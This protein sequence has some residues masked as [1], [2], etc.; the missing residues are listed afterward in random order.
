MTN[1]GPEPIADVTEP[2]TVLLDLPFDEGD[3]PGLR[4]TVAAHATRTSLSAQR[5][6]DLILI[7]SELAA[8]AVRHGGGGGRLRLWRTAGAVHCR[9]TDDGP[10]LPAPY[11]APRQRPDPTV[12][13]GRGLWL[14][15][16]FADAL[17]VGGGPNGGTAV[18]ATMRLP[19]RTGTPGEPPRGRHTR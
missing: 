4:R 9:V 17:D 10:G 16:N 3:L 5:V 7:V 18:T 19:E 13:G 12:A 1:C 11:R 15:L 6:D 14:V 2:S 8:N